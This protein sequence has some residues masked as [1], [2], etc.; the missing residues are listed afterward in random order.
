[1]A[2]S[3]TDCKPDGSPCCVKGCGKVKGF[4]GQLL[5]DE[6]CLTG[7]LGLPSIHVSWASLTY[8]SS[9]REPPPREMLTLSPGVWDAPFYG[10]A[11]GAQEVFL[12]TAR[13][14][15]M[16]LNPDAHKKTLHC[17]CAFVWR[18]LNKYTPDNPTRPLS[19]YKFLYIFSYYP[20]FLFLRKSV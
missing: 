3:H 10:N 7:V 16:A 12:F 14:W 9:P 2:V 8:F 15:A 17:I 18:S 4:F 5:I 13:V 6:G 20:T 11:D 19:C 1:M